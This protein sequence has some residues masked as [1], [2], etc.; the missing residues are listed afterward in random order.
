MSK[1]DK[2]NI[3]GVNF[4]Y[5]TFDEALEMLMGFLDGD[6]PRAVFTPNPEFVMLARK[7]PEY[8]ALLNGADAVLPDGIGI[9]LASRLGRHKLKG[10]ITGYDIVQAI[11][12]RIRETD[13]TVYFYGGAPGVAD[14]ARLRMEETHPGLRIVGAS[15]GYLDDAGQEAMTEEIKRLKPDILL[16]GTGSPR[17]ERWIS[18][19]KENLPCKLFIG[20]GG[21]FDVMSGR[22][23]RVP[24]LIGDMGFEWLY[25][26]IKEP[27]RIKRQV[28]LPLF[29]LAVI[30]ERFR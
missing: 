13:K 7:D 30:R 9:V 14:E 3:L 24:K 2:I 12:S 20:V 8:K 11:F 25:R 26:L 15:N 4:G 18:L 27:K 22:I 17:Q 1:P 16:A 10:R 28:Q 21:S 19:H 23:P 6:R 29:I 5:L